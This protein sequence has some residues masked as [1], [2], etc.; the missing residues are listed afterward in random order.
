M[1]YRHTVAGALQLK[2]YA[3]RDLL[4]RLRPLC[5]A[6]AY[7]SVDYRVMAR[8]FGLPWLWMNAGQSREPDNSDTIITLRNALAVLERCG[9]VSVKSCTHDAIAVRL[10]R[11]SVCPAIGDGET[12]GGAA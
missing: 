6:D 3:I 10:R 8:W 1:K 7:T 9:Y 5:S 11:S 12:V 2:N 4:R